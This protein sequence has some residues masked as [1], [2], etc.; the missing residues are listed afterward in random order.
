[1]R[2]ALIRRVLARARAA[3]ARAARRLRAAN[4]VVN[5][6]QA[7]RHTLPPSDGGAA[8]SASTSMLQT[9]DALRAGAAFDDRRRAEDR[10]RRDLTIRVDAELREAARTA[11]EAR[12]IVGER[13]ARAEALEAHA[14]VAEQDELRRAEARREDDPPVRRRRH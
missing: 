3:E 13:R 9:V 12:R 14:R 5:Q 7:V 4:D 8:R 1:M 10:R 2:A 11:S 6:L